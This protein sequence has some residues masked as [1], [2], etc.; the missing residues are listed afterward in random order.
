MKTRKSGKRFPSL[1][2]YR[3]TMDRVWRT[4]L[5]FGLV[6]L[7]VWA[8]TMFRPD[9][10]F[11]GGESWFLV[12]AIVSLSLS[13]FSFIARFLAYVQAHTNYLSVVT[14]FLRM[15]VSYRRVQSFRPVLV[16]QL[17][18][19]GDSGWAERNFLEPFYGKTAVVMDLRGYPINP[20]LLRLFLPA[21]MFSRRS[22]GLVFVVPDWMEFST[23]MDTF[24]GTWLQSQGIRPRGSIRNY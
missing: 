17:F 12:G 13:L 9:S 20:T 22:K 16:Q 1:L 2:L 23:E 4:T 3:R 10:Y 7:S 21:Q 19:P 6:L 15:K 18:P 8:W 24:H 5:L 14:P 11:G